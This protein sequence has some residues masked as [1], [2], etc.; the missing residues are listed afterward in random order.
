MRF[1][2]NFL[3]DHIVQSGPFH[4]ILRCQIFADTVHGP[5]PIFVIDLW[6]DRSFLE[7]VLI[8]LLLTVTLYHF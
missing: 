6:L 7:L 2:L 5:G 1:H 3:S 4:P 8:S